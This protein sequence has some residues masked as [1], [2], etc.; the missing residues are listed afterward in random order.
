M[1]ITFSPSAN[2]FYVKAIHGDNIPSDAV[3]ISDEKH[4]ALLD[5]QSNG[6]IITVGPGGVPY[7]SDP[8][9][10]TQEQEIAKYEAALDAHLDSVAQQYRYR[11]RVT[12]SLRAG[13]AGPYQP[14]GVAFAQ[15][16]DLCN[17]Q[18][19]TLLGDVL[20]GTAVLPTVEDFIAGLPAFVLP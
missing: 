3:E 5:G 13:Y 7:L 15:W 20:S 14:E 10:P 9:P 11:D 1:T 16:M 2:G 8:A 18:A 4:A 17:V 6:K 19:F 12:F